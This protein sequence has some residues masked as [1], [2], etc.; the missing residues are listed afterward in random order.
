MS[1]RS[2]IAERNR[3]VDHAWRFAAGERIAHINGASCSEQPLADRF[4]DRGEFPIGLVKPNLGRLRAKLGCDGFIF[5]RHDG[6][7]GSQIQI[8]ESAP[9]PITSLARAGTVDGAAGAVVTA[10]SSRCGN[11]GSLTT[12]AADTPMRFA[13]R[14]TT[15]I[16]AQTT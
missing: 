16:N 7:R 11:P 4:L 3:R 8:R 2:T 12:L 10:A 14:L 13:W 6:A 5:R 15:I 9:Y 1:A